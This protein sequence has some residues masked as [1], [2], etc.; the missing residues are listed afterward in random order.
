[1]ACYETVGTFNT[2]T[3]QWNILGSQPAQTTNLA[4]YQSA[5]FD[6]S[7]CSWLV[8]GTQQIYSTPISACGSFTWGN[9]GQIYAES[10][11]ELHEPEA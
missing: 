9:N 1:M 5:T 10:E 11:K 8:S 2:G 4:C 7:S 3:C 6:T